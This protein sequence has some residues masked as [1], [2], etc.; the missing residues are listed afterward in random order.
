MQFVQAQ[1]AA[2][3]QNYESNQSKV[4]T[5]LSKVLTTLTAFSAAVREGVNKAEQDEA[6]A[7][8]SDRELAALGLSREDLP[9]FI[10][11]A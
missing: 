10:G 8:K 3:L 9:R 4:L 11:L 5:T 2:L 1:F 6:L 7:R